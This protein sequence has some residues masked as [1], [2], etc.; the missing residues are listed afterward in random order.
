MLR[1][2]WAAGVLL[3]GAVLLPAAPAVAVPADPTAT[4]ARTYAL[5]AAADGSLR[6]TRTSIAARAGSV[7]LRLR[8]P[9]SNFHNI[10]FGTRRGRVVGRGG[11]STV[12]AR[13]KPGRY[14]YFCSVPGHRA[15]GMR[16]TLTVR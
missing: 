16:G 1:P 9:S 14:L 10:A 12:S 4:S 13:L 8:N 11:V 2:S 3:A 15:A 6:F 7:T 5:S